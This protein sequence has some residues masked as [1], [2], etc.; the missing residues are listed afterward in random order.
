[1]F[2]GCEFF[3]CKIL[4]IGMVCARVCACVQ[5]CSLLKGL[6]ISGLH[7][8]GMAQEDQ[9]SESNPMQMSPTGK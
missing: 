1:M 4:H 8:L 6:K 2:P 5:I 9:D 3:I 7:E